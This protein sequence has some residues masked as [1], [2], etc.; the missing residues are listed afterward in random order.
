MPARQFIMG[1]PGFKIIEF[2]QDRFLEIF[3]KYEG[4]RRCIHCG[5]VDLRTKDSFLRRV[6]HASFGDKLT[7]I[8][9]KAHKFKCLDC[10]K[11]FN[12]RF[13]GIYPRKRATEKF[14][15]EVYRRHTDGVSQKKLSHRVRVGQAAIERWSQDYLKFEESKQDRSRWPRVLGIDEHF[16][17]YLYLGPFLNKYVY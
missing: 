16:F 17:K 13:P 4:E 12:Q 6:R 10:G 14:R 15:Q 7:R 3:V 9:I 8:N 2:K 1:L 5:S 11:Y